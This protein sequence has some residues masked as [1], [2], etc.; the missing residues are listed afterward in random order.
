MK[1]VNPDLAV[2]VLYRDLMTDGFA[3]DAAIRARREGVVFIPY[4]RE[5]KPEV[6]L[7]GGDGA[8]HLR[9]DVI[10]PILGRPLTVEADLLV[11]S[12]G[13]VS[14]LDTDLA[15]AY[16]AAVDQDGFFAEAETKWRPLDAIA[17]GVFACGMAQGPRGI[18]ES[19]ATG[20]AA[21]QRCIRILRRERLPSGR[22]VA[23]VRHSLC[24]LCRRC[25]DDCPFDARF[26]DEQR[27]EIV[28]HPALCQGCGSC[29]A[30]CP[31]GAAVVSGMGEKPMLEAIDAALGGWG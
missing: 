20:R 6:R 8:G 31:N 19:L 3:E 25:I 29:A 12:T 13:V 17:D 9:L 26:F 27:E 5:R 28:V 21:A 2:F 14:N 30:V 11:L 24:S 4:D 23:R 15:V 7:D 1:S 16:G 18:R 22:P 10:D